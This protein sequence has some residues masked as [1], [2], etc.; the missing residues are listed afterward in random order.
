VLTV[1][2]AVAKI[3]AISGT[4]SSIVFRM[5]I[6]AVGAVVVIVTSSSCFGIRLVVVDAIA[7]F[8]NGCS[9]CGLQ[10]NGPGGGGG[11]GCFPGVKASTWITKTSHTTNKP[12]SEYFL[13]VVL[14][15]LL[16][17]HIIMM[18]MIHFTEMLE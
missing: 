13:R 6:R 10:E 12:T 4:S 14:L 1:V 8:Q 11:G 15:L 5:R 3:R 18:M 16:L 7:D 9:S 2:A 17:Q